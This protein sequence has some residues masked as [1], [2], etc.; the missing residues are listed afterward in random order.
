M[1]QQP[2]TGHSMVLKWLPTSQKLAICTIITSQLLSRSILLQLTTLANGVVKHDLCNTSIKHLNR[3]KLFCSTNVI[4]RYKPDVTVFIL[5]TASG[6]V[7]HTDPS[8]A[9][10][11]RSKIIFGS[12]YHHSNNQAI[13]ISFS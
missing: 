4:A 10:F 3:N 12:L 1:Q 11:H 5:A 2:A 6:L 7:H 13:T 9:A 8:Y